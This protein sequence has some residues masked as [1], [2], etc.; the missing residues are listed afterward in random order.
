MAVQKDITAAEIIKVVREA[1]ER[2][3]PKKPSQRFN[4]IFRRSDQSYGAERIKNWL[5][6]LRILWK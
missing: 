1:K 2:K 6:G 5:G 3:A 4:L